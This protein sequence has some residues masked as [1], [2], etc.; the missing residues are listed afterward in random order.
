MECNVLTAAQIKRRSL[1]EKV[2]PKTTGLLLTTVPQGQV[3]SWQ[4][5]PPRRCPVQGAGVLPPGHG[6]YQPG[7]DS[8]AGTCH[9]LDQW[10]LLILILFFAPHPTA[11][12][13]ARSVFLPLGP[14]YVLLTLLLLLLL[15]VT[16]LDHLGQFPGQQRAGD[17][18]RGQG[19]NDGGEET[20]GVFG[21]PLHDILC[22]CSHIN[23]PAQRRPASTRTKV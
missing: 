7:V 17:E 21:G 18:Q 13:L 12:P 15:A 1:L 5:C 3:S 10:G 9:Y 4:Y 16:C 6:A 23:H 19:Q 2:K 8:R 22:P 11:A 20:V 14:V